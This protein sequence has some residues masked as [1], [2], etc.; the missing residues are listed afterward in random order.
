MPEFQRYLVAAA[1]DQYDDRGAA[2]IDGDG[3]PIGTGTYEEWWAGPKKNKRIYR[4]TGFT[5]TVYATSSGLLR[6]D[7]PANP[8]IAELEVRHNLLRPID[9][10]KRAPDF[11]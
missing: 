4:S 9:E 5:Q 7:N 6:R 2:G 11:Q 3:K 10:P 1:A 8:R